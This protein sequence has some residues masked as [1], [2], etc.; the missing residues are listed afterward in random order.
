MHPPL[1]KPHPRCQSVIDTLVT[2]H[3]E[4]PYGK[5]W[6]SCNDAKV[7]LDKCFYDE[8]EERRRANREKALAFDAEYARELDLRKEELKR[9]ADR[10]ENRNGGTST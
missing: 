3:E 7:A 1:R 6:G 2:C 5:F 4:N 10:G 9:D 8:K